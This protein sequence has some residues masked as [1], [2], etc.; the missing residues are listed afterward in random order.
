MKQTRFPILTMAS[1]LCMQFSHH[2]K[3]LVIFFVFK[4]TRKYEK[5]NGQKKTKEKYYTNCYF[6]QTRF[7]YKTHESGD[8]GRFYICLVDVNTVN[9]IKIGH[10]MLLLVNVFFGDTSKM[11]WY[12][13]IQ[14]IKLYFFGKK[15]NSQFYSLF[16]CLFEWWMSYQNWFVTLKNR[17]WTC[18]YRNPILSIYLMV[19][20]DFFLFIDT[21]KTQIKILFAAHR[22]NQTH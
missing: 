18:F 7:T 16:I 20:D 10:K 6:M 9:Y 8:F 4:I 21:T 3:R 19:K 12:Q 17:T 11:V 14:K 5:K 15:K 1:I 2:S 22:K 13:S